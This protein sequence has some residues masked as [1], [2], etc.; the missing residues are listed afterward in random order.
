VSPARAIVV[1]G[2]F[3]AALLAMLIG[4]MTHS[5]IAPASERIDD[6]VTLWLVFGFPAAI[7]AALAT[8]WLSSDEYWWPS[9]MSFA[10]ILGFS[11]RCVGLAC[12]LLIPI[13]LI[14]GLLHALS[15]AFFAHQ[16]HA[17]GDFAL[18]VLSFPI[19]DAIAILFGFLPALI[20]QTVVVLSA[21]AVEKWLGYA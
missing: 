2:S 19:V 16:S 8:W 1:F 17:S 3:S 21:R 15:N 11:V 10:Q 14:F 9:Q 4:N 13:Q 12:L 18:S 7:A 6:G 20:L 5:H